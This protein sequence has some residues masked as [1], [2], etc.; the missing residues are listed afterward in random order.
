MTRAS[1]LR[2]AASSAVETA[3]EATAEA[4]AGEAAETTAAADG[5]LAKAAGQLGLLRRHPPVA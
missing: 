2:K 1:A 5:G 4:A 3:R